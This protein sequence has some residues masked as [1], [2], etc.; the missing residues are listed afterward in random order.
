[1]KGMKNEIN[2]IKR[3]LEWHFVIAMVF[4]GFA[5]FK[6]TRLETRNSVWRCAGSFRVKVLGTLSTA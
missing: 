4:D 2:D 1:M 5:Q 6:V 3:F